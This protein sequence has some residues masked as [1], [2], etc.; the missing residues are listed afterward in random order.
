MQV[1]TTAP[2]PLQN[3]SQIINCKNIPILNI[4]NFNVYTKFIVTSDPKIGE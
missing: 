1:L 2:S 3:D 4:P